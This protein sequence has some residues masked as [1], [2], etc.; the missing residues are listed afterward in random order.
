M[1]YKSVLRYFRSGRTPEGDSMAELRIGVSID[2]ELLQRFDSYIAD[3]GYEN[4]SE[5]LATI[6]GLSREC[7]TRQIPLTG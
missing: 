6:P 3:K 5:A 4:H 2:S 7:G 1:F